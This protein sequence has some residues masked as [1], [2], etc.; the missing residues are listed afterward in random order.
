MNNVSKKKNF[1]GELIDKYPKKR[2]KLSLKLKRIF[3][4]EYKINRENKLNSFFEKWMHKNIL[5]S[6]NISNI[7]TL[8]I[9]AGTLNHLMYEDLKKKDSYDIIEP[10]KFL[11]RDN[12][13]KKRLTGYIL[14][15]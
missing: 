4:H 15:I 6:Q 14:I 11:F 5:K 12:I 9:G 1:L 13:L 10:K 2:A 7:N 3:K 8:E